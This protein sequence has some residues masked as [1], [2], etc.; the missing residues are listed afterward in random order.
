MKR[1]VKA[2]LFSC[3][4]FP[5]V[6]QMYLRRYA[7]GMVFMLPAAAGLVFVVNY[8]VQQA[9]SLVGE[10][11][12]GAVPI[13]ATRIAELVAATPGGP[14]NMMSNI[15]TYV[16]VACWVASIIDAYRIGSIEDQKAEARDVT[17]MK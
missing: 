8:A 4:V 3:F 7:R 10:I 14:E 9:L 5:G 2:A 11:E 12:S 6:G 1:S 15:A 13:D 17:T 16:I